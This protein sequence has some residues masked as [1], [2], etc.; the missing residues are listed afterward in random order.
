MEHLRRMRLGDLL[1][2]GGK[3]TQQQLI[4]ALNK[5]KT[6][7]KRLGEVLISEGIAKEEDII[8]ILEK[9]LG[10]PRVNIE[11]LEINGEAVR[12]ITA[13]LANKHTILPV[14][15]KDN[16]IQVVMSDPMN[17]IALD[18]IRIATGFEAEPFIATSKEIKEAI[19]K[20]YSSQFVLK[21]AD[22]LSKETGSQKTS[23]KAREEEEASQD[24]VKNAPVVKLVD[25]IV[26]NA[27]R[28]R[29][30]DIHIEP[31]EKYVKVRYRVDGE[32]S[33]VL[34]TPIDNLGAMITRVKILS[35]LNIAEKRIPQDG[36]ILTTVDNKAIDLRVSVLPTVNGE[37]VVIRILSRSNFMVGK[38]R[39]GM[40]PD[41]LSKLEKIIANPHGIILVTGPT[42]SGK[43]TTL[44]TILGELNTEDKNI[45]TV[46]DPV[47]FLLEGIN[48]V[49]VNTKAGLTFAAGLRSILR[50]DP[51]IIM[52]GEIR[53]GE[54]AEIA[55]RSAITGHLVLSTIHTNDAPSSVTRLIDMGIEPYL[56]ATS[57]VGVVAQR[58]VRRLCPQCSEVYEATEYEKTLLG[59]IP[60]IPVYLKRPTGCSFCSNS[61]YKGR[62]GIYEIMEIKR[63]QREMILKDCSMDELKD[64]CMKEG[65]KTLRS[66]CTEHVLKGVTSMDELMRVAYLKE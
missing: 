63:T 24:E 41:D 57:V 40:A 47:E 23:S 49:S 15:F 31:F 60:E 65:M 44:Y 56:I 12:S 46:E 45:I 14:A 53:D 22:E 33:E 5:Q 29:A 6:S 38:E 1:V 48:Q 50:Q 62:I 25:S 4:N 54:T 2:E 3:I 19:S 18:D 34:R 30:S 26:E 36:R 8:S 58:L 64:A 16:K 7:G 42:G 43:S 37:K 11:L 9:Q 39:L 55:I 66:S 13:N 35:G 21:A 61:G 51:D 20:L 59:L 32:L 28:S 17:I 27:V 52:L 10:I